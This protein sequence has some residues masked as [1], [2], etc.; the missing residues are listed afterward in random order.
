MNTT[1]DEQ[2]RASFEADAEPYEYSLQRASCGCCDYT[3][4]RTEDR[5]NGWKAALASQP[6]AG[7]PVAIATDDDVER[8]AKACGWNNRGYMTPADYAIWCERMRDFVRRATAQ[9]PAPVVQETAPPADGGV[10]DAMVQ[11]AID[12]FGMQPSFAAMK[13]A[14][15]A[16]LKARGA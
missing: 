13:R 15:E 5:W 11:A 8:L 1:N 14:L 3:S 2:M 9:T 16:A 4:V 10:T 12:T 6:V 7:E